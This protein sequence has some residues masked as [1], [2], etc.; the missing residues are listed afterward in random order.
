ME[1]NEEIRRGAEAERLLE[2]PLLI[3]CFEKIQDGI[4]QA[5]NGSALGDSETHHRL[6][7]AMQLKNQLERQLKD[8]ATTGKMAKLQVK[9]GTLG[10]LRAAAGF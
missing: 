6:V 5:M 1:L 7:I 3:E 4:I 2:N 8:I 9:D 10:K